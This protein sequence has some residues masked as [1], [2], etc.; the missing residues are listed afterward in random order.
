MRAS[1]QGNVR[2][3][4]GA[5]DFVRIQL[6]EV[7][8]PAG[9]VLEDVV[10]ITSELVTNAVQA[11]ATA[12]GIALSASA[13]RLDLTVDD[14]AAGWPTPRQAQD[15]E[16]NGRGLR[17]VDRLADSWTVT[18]DARGKRITATWYPRTR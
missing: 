10:L 13:D 18:P 14:N 2:A 11:G 5:R 4:I 6:T 17:I 3:P 8:L 1:L 9:V 12:V 15:H 7:E 16:P